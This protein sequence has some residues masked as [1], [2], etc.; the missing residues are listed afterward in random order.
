MTTT[1]K[2]YRPKFKARVAIE[3]I[4]GEKTLCA[5]SAPLRLGSFQTTVQSSVHPELG[6]APGPDCTGTECRWLPA[7]VPSSV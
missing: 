7:F 4:R 2:Q 1:R 5:S 6:L 3:A